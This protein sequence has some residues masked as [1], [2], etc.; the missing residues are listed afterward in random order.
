MTN[1]AKGADAER[2]CKRL[3]EMLGYDVIRSAGSKG[4]WD[5]VS[6]Y[7]TH[8][9]LIQVKVEGAM[10]PGEHEAIELYTTPSFCTKEV[11][12]RLAGKKAEERWDVE[13]VR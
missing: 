9:R 8:V 5:I 12:T 11:W 2:E 3:L 13:V 7:P 10:T 1:Y 4:M 6:V